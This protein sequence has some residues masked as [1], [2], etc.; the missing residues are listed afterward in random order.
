MPSMENNEN[1]LPGHH[2]NSRAALAEHGP[3][4]GVSRNLAGRPT[5]SRNIR[6]RLHEMLNRY[7]DVEALKHLDGIEATIEL[8]QA[9]DRRQK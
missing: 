8:L 4:K 7:V 2:P 1:T 6:T 3:P 5:G 9:T